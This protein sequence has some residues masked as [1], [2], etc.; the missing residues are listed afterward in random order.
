MKI[1][2]ITVTD[3][4]KGLHKDAELIAWAHDK[5]PTTQVEIIYLK[6][7]ETAK[8]ESEFVGMCMAHS[9]LL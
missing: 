3:P 8:I 9:K 6:T 7:I 5:S 4:S 1:G 2:V